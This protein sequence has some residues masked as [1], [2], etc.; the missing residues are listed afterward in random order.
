VE[1]AVRPGSYA[2]RYAKHSTR[3]G[4]TTLGKG[5]PGMS[6]RLAV[7]PSTQHPTGQDL[8]A[9]LASKDPQA[10]QEVIDRY[11][12]LIRK[13]ARSRG[14]QA[15]EAEDVVQT[16]W[17]RLLLHA[18]S[19]HN[20]ERLATWLATTARREASHVLRL[21]GRHILVGDDT[22]FGPGPDAMPA[23]DLSLLR[24]ERD[25]GLWRALESLPD[26]CGR[27]LKLLLTDPPPSYA[28]V[29]AE[30]GM[31]VGSIGPTRA[32]CL[33]CLRRRKEVQAELQPDGR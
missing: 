23:A 31:P 19:V 9:R 25:A 2:N 14:L 15:N 30:L 1:Q 29:A 4:A 13:V 21:A 16:T 17:L 10:W 18:G 6:H 12:G 27:L 8:L 33:D 20:A 26:R 3:A 24:S 22:G 32:R 7:R 11:E 28:K 5:R